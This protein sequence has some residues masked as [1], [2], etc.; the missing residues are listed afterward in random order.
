MMTRKESLPAD[1][2]GKTAVDVLCIGAGPTGLGAAKRLNQ[3]ATKSWAVIDSSDSAGG[4]ASTDTTPEGFLFDVG[5]HVI[6]SHYSYFDDVLDEILPEKDD[7]R[8]HQRVSYVRSRNTWVPYPYQNNISMLPKDDQVLAMSG[9][10]DAYVAS[11]TGA[12]KP[13]NFDEWIVMNMGEGIADLFMRPYNFKV[14][15]V[16]TTR[17]H[18]EWLGERVA[19]PDLKLTL[20]NV[21]RNRTAGNW[22]PNV[23][24]SFPAK[25]GTGGIWKG[26]ARTLPEDHIRL[27]TT[28]IRIDTVNNNVLTS[29]GF[30]ISY[31]SLIS[32][33]PVDI[34]CR[35]L[36]PPRPDLAACAKKLHFSKTH[37][38]GVGIHG[39]RPDNIGDK[40][41]LYFPEDDAPFYRATV[42]SS[43]AEANVPAAS[44]AIS[45]LRRADNGPVAD[46]TPQPGPYWSLMF[47]VA[48]SAYKPVDCD[49]L[50][51]DTIQGSSRNWFG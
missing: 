4:L 28:A 13:K 40:C 30:E 15:A 41:W 47:E 9:M 22:G 21:I 16:P 35:I 33:M 19:A 44:V 20:T 39:E 14:W 37:V 36:D 6:F 2:V 31:G 45:T 7:W 1:R 3:L 29:D 10:V 27:S 48:E 5:G 18:C 42:F 32:T 49:R 26:V 34:L 38:I 8:Y 46:S 24:F 51:E 17:M 43:Y 25:D 50:V 11:K 12:Q 23:T